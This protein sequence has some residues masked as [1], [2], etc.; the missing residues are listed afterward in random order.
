MEVMATRPAPNLLSEEEIR[1]RYAAQDWG[2]LVDYVKG[3][4]PSVMRAQL[5]QPAQQSTGAF[6]SVN[7]GTSPKV[8]AE[9]ARYC[10]KDGV[11]RVRLVKGWDRWHDLRV[12]PICWEWAID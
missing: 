2:F 4:M 8:L 1:K 9:I 6:S 11:K 5:K 7:P 12:C 3:N 10:K